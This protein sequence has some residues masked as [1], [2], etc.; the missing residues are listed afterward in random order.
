MRCGVMTCRCAERSASRRRVLRCRA[1]GAARPG[2]RVRAAGAALPGRRALRCRGGG[3]CAS[4][5][6][7]LRVRAAGVDNS[8]LDPR[9]GGDLRGFHALRGI[10]APGLSAATRSPRIAGQTCV[11][12]PERRAS[13]ELSTGP[14]ASE[15]RR[16]TS[17][18]PA[19]LGSPPR[20]RYPPSN[21]IRCRMANRAMAVPRRTCDLP[22]AAQETRNA[23][24]KRE[25]RFT[26]QC[27][28]DAAIDCTW[29]RAQHNSGCASSH[30]APCA[31]SHGGPCASSHGGPCASST[32][33]PLT[34][35]EPRDRAY[36]DGACCKAAWCR[37]S[38][39]ARARGHCNG[40]GRSIP[41]NRS[42][43]ATSSRCLSAGP[44]GRGA[45]ACAGSNAGMR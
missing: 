44:R 20:L 17:I 41:E 3:R 12:P 22:A 32:N 40:C 14:P 35:I 19:P 5:R 1:A 8:S 34:D 38:P 21:A 31:S 9:Y 33:T 37:Q 4:G 15:P 39:A 6:R 28:D 42:P 2:L 43:A 27:G 11:T 26:C 10:R 29:E 23:S 13:D 36:D 18:G 24:P 25:P 30:R 7:A 45:F 16:Q